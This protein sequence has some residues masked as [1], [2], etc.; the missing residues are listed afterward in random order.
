MKD[1]LEKLKLYFVND[2]NYWELSKNET[3]QTYIISFYPLS[4]RKRLYQN[5][6]QHFDPNGIPLFHS[7]TG[8]LVHFVTGMCSFVFA[9]WEEYLLTGDKKHTIH[10]L[11]IAEYLLQ[12]AENRKNGGLMLLDYESDKRDNGISCAMN[13]GEAISVMIRAYCLT[14]DIKYLNAAEKMAI[15]FLFPFGNEGVSGKLKQNGQIW[16]LEGGKTILNGHIYAIFGLQELNSIL[17]SEWIKNLIDQGLNSIK[18]SINLFDNGYWSWYWLET[19]LYIASAMYHN[20][21][22]C[23]LNAL[24]KNVDSNIFESS[25]KQFAMYASSPANRIKAAL[26]MFKAKAR[27]RLKRK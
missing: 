7:K 9:H 5:H 15:P 25:S 23:Q 17:K 21:H 19:P 14:N 13:Q 11:N 3:E 8:E 16:Y 20:L 6:Y 24:A 12:I 26:I 10:I 4:F 18:N 1:F 27:N 22:I 2:P